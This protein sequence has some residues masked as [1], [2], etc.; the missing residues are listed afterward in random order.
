MLNH[1]SNVSLFCSSDRSQYVCKIIKAVSVESKVTNQIKGNK[2][3][4]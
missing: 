3:T 1:F 2:S 4:L